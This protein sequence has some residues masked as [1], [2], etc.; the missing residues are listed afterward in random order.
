MRLLAEAL[1]ADSEDRAVLEAAAS[2]SRHREWGLAFAE[3]AADELGRRDQV[4]WFRR[5]M[6]EHDNLRAALDAYRA[7]VDGADA[8]LRLA[9]ALGQFWRMQHPGQGRYRLAEALARANTEPSSARAAALSW[10]ATIEA[11]FGDPVTARAGAPGSVRRAS[12]GRCA[13]PTLKWPLPGRTGRCA[14]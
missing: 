5:L 2:S 9:A 1:Q 7:D 6:A 8:E 13:L 4:A 3:R 14:Q 12:G 11:L 10:R